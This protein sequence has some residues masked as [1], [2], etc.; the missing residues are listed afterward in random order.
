MDIIIRGRASKG[1]VK[2]SERDEM[3]LRVRMLSGRHTQ[4]VYNSVVAELGDERAKSIGKVDMSRNVIRA[5][6]DRRCKA[7][8]L[9]P[10]VEDLPEAFAALIGDM[11]ARTTVERYAKAGGR[12]MPVRMSTVSEQVYR[13]RVGCNWSG[14]LL[15]WA[16]ASAKPYAQLVT[17]DDLDVQYRSDDPLAPTVITHTRRRRRPDGIEYEAEEVYDLTDLDA[18]TYR[19]F[20]G[21]TDRT[22]E[23][24]DGVLGWDGGWLSLWRYQDGR[25]FHRII[26]SGDPRRAYEGVELVEGTLR[27]AAGYTHVFAG[28]RDAGFPTTHAIGL[29]HLGASADGS[30]EAT[31]ISA[32]PEIIQEWAH[33]NPDR[34]GQLLQHGP[35]FDPKVTGEA[36]RAYELGL[37]ESTGLPVN[38][39][40][41]GGEP[42][43]TEAAALAEIIAATY[44]DC[45]MHDGLVLRRLAAISNRASELLG[46][47]FDL[48]ERSL[49]V[50][51]REEIAA[52][53]PEPV[54]P[55]EL[56][57][58]EP[59]DDDPDPDE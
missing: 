14:T 33:T 6:V 46:T 40:R 39:E 10:L 49:S 7:Y 22:G 21:D 59:P 25:P 11:N 29:T 34:P 35:G 41:T 37:L 53:M 38:Y 45:R 42:T 4:D 32:G 3:A 36:V 43:A 13:H 18:P 5:N 57:S 19:V 24:M 17:P 48:P 30:Q 51:Y 47:P 50:L 20:D 2:R 28:L 9:P 27:V 23:V 58:T 12:P 26:I 55:V 15:A 44:P 31:G 52:A 1:L 16:D 54:E 56:E 8:L